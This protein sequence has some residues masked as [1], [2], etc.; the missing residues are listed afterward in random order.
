MWDEEIARKNRAPQ[1]ASTVYIGELNEGES[2][3]DTYDLFRC[4]QMVHQGK[5]K[6][7]HD[8]MSEQTVIKV[9][10]QSPDIMKV[11]KRAEYS[12]FKVKYNPTL[13]DY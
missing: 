6:T 5:Q 11:A 3:A 13:D 12:G 4:E 9:S 8:Y 7:V 2:A 1:G 10:M